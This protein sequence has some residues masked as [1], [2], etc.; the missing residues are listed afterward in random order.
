M[1]AQRIHPPLLFGQHV[2]DTQ[3]VGLGELQLAQGFLFFAFELGDSRSFFE[4]RAAFFGLGREDLVDLPLRHDRVRGAANARVHQQ[5]VDVLETAK[6]AVD[7]VF[8][9]SIAEYPAGEGHFVVVHLQR[10]FAVSHGQ[11]HLGHS[12]GLALFR[13]VENHVCH[14]TTTQRLGRRFAQHPADR[15]DHVGLAAA[16]RADDAR[17]PLGKLEHGLVGKRLETLDLERFK[18]HGYQAGLKVK[19]QRWTAASLAASL[20]LA[21]RDSQ[22]A[23][24]VV[25]YFRHKYWMWCFR[26]FSIS[27]VI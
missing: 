5:V 13:A 15:V 22:M 2:G 14:L 11:C 21:I 1:A 23:L 25:F 3:Q 19:S 9:S 12:Q 27:K 8:R 10:A 18:I 4:H 20:R 26:V 7:P 16:V 24:Y 17:H 6:G